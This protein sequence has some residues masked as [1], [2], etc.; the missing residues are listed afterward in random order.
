KAITVPDDVERKYLYDY[1]CISSD[2][3]N[4][5]KGTNYDT[6]L[7][8]LEAL[9]D[10][11]DDLN[12]EPETCSYRTYNEYVCKTNNLYQKERETDCDTGYTLFLR[13]C[14]YGC[15]DGSCKAE[16]ENTCTYQEF[17]DFKCIGDVKY[18]KVKERDCSVD[19]SL[20]VG[21]CNVDLS[22]DDDII[23]VDT[24]ETSED[25]DSIVLGDGFSDVECKAYEI[26][27]NKNALGYTTDCKFDFK[28][29]FSNQGL[30]TLWK[31]YPNYI[32]GSLMIFVII[33]LLIVIRVRGGKKK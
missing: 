33:V 15:E 31:D 22:G 26:G 1:K 3:P 18:Q 23:I 2:N 8:C 21:S 30:K 6:E 10:A 27:Y 13:R 5:D 29:S 25:N 24:N 32:I 9:A 28:K 11:L 12:N 7:K 20:P 16:P 17:N 14:D 4:W 19:Y